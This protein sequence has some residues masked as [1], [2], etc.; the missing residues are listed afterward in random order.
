MTTTHTTATT[1]LG[2]QTREHNDRRRIEAQSEL[3]LLLKGLLHYKALCIGSFVLIVVIAAYVIMAMPPY[4]RAVATLLYTQDNAASLLDRSAQTSASPADMAE[5]NTHLALANSRELVRTSLQRSGVTYDEETQ[6]LLYLDT[7]SSTPDE[8]SIAYVHENLSV[9]RQGK[10]H[11]LQITLRAKDPDIAMRLANAHAATV[12]AYQKE[13]ARDKMQV[14]NDNLSRLIVDLKQERAKQSQQVQQSFARTGIIDSASQEELFYKEIF[15]I[16]EE[17]V[18][19]QTRKDALQAQLDVLSSNGAGSTAAVPDN[20]A[21]S[22]ALEA[23]RSR[24]I[25]LREELSSL[26][27]KYQPTHPLYREKQ[28]SYDDVLRQRNAEQA[29]VQDAISTELRAVV[30]QEAAL[31]RRM[32]R[33]TQQAAAFERNRSDI[34]NLQL[35]QLVSEKLLDNFLETYGLLQSQLELSGTSFS[36]VAPATLP[37]SPAEP[38]KLLLA[39]LAVLFAG[40]LSITVSLVVML[41]RDKIRSSYDIQKRLKLRLAA[42]VPSVK[43]PQG[44]EVTKEKALYVNEIRRIYLYLKSQHRAKVIL[45]TS[46]HKKEGKSLLATSLASYVS[47]LGKRTI[48][49]S[50]DGHIHAAAQNPQTEPVTVHSAA[51]QKTYAPAKRATNYLSEREA[52]IRLSSYVD[53]TGYHHLTLFSDS[54]RTANDMTLSAHFARFIELLKDEYDLVILDADAINA[55]TDAEVISSSVDQIMIVTWWGKTSKRALRRAVQRVM[56]FTDIFPAV[57]VN[58]TPLSLG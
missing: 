37:V 40:F 18:P 12:I 48:L 25:L 41:L 8:T 35:E 24:T 20:V 26:A 4:Y 38:N 46:T 13:Q 14:L 36:M 15:A 21:L 44:T 5:L 30:Q 28:A 53:E 16:Q 10:S 51:G 56:R 31:L 49:I 1:P 3:V 58:R 34:D 39:I 7:M 45:F 57:I 32:S 6:R 54:E 9:A 17:L 55:S 11:L 2:A 42:M 47:S 29:R 27:S 52:G 43:Q 50:K 22:P 33:L 19:L 23:L